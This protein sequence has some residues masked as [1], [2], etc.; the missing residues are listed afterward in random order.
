MKFTL[1]NGAKAVAAL[2]FLA[3]VTPLATSSPSEASL[4]VSSMAA[5]AEP[6]A[7]LVSM[8]HLQKRQEPGHD[9]DH[10]HPAPTTTGHDHAAPGHDEHA[11]HDHGEHEGHEDEHEGHG[12]EES[13]AGH[14][15]G[16]ARVCDAH[17]HAAEGEYVVWHHIVALVVLIVVASLGCI[18]PM[19]MRDNQ[20]TRYF[21]QCGK[22]FGAGVVLSVAFVHIMPEALFALTHPCLSKAW[23]DDYPGYAPLIMMMSGLT[24]LVIEYLASSLVLKVEAQNKKAVVASTSGD[25]LESNA[26]AH[27]SDKHD[28]AGHASSSSSLENKPQGLQDDCNHAHG[29]TL[30]QCGPGVSTKVSTY[31]LEAGI[32][33]HS[34]FIGI[35]LGVLAGSE[36]LAMTIAICFHQFFEGIALGSRIADLTFRRR[37]MPVLLVAIFAL[38]TP[39]GIAIGMGMRTSYRANSVENLIIMGVC[40]SIAC[41]V[42]IYTAYVTLLGGD[43]LYSERFRAESRANKASYLVAVWLGAIAMAVIALW[44]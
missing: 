10:D 2:L 11:G 42:L 37:L 32:T 22:Y 43:I 19:I 26:H 31:M 7:Q 17:N 14:S 13:E 34:V 9:H 1:S 29:L 44:A 8:S 30:L 3:S 28:H 16:P 35:S 27:F 18:L 41:G 24:M 25:A 4:D 33:L 20:R 5:V 12:P 40:N 6:V 15:H 21:V 38:I 23:T 36:F 39:V